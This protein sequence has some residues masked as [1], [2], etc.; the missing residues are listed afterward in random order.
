MSTTA[1]KI[2]I[3]FSVAMNVG[4]SLFAVYFHVAESAERRDAH[5]GSDRHMSFYRRLDL[6]A[7]QTA[8][9]EK[10]IRE[11]APEQRK[12]KGENKN[13]EKALI[14]VLMEKEPDRRQADQIL[15]QMASLK[16]SREEMTFEHLMKVRSLL[17]DRQAREMF[18]SLLQHAEKERD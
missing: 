5:K 17:S 10:L 12:M 16:R 1:K 2:L 7:D 14:T 15:D 11:Y 8:N 13:L 6:S 4:F 9:I 18:S 3:L